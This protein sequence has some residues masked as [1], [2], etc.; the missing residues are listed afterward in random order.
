MDISKVVRDILYRAYS[1]AKNNKNE[2][3][4]PE[5]LLL[6]ALEED[7]FK[8]VII[9]LNGNVD[10]LKEDLTS[11]INENLDKLE[12]EGEPEES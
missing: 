1:T 3:V 4:T 8:A 10:E 5:H 6:S 7:A 9:K 12:D 2:Y 11:Y